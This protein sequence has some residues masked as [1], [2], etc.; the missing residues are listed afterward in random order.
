[1][2]N[3]IDGMSLEKIQEL[4]HKDSLI[5]WQDI[6]TSALVQHIVPFLPQTSEGVKVRITPYYNLFC[7]GGR[8]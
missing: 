1:L 4:I 5:Y 7:I 2:I 3:L 6:K 8:Y